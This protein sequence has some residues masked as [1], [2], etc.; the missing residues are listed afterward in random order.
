MS[1]TRHSNT[2]RWLL[3]HASPLVAGG[4]AQCVPA[5]KTTRLAAQGTPAADLF[6]LST[7]I[8]YAV[9][10][11]IP[12]TEGAEQQAQVMCA[13]LSPTFATLLLKGVHPRPQER[14]QSVSELL[15]AMGQHPTRRDQGMRRQRRRSTLGQFPQQATPSPMQ[16]QNHRAPVVPTPPVELPRRAHPPQGGRQR[17]SPEDLSPVAAGRDRLMA[18]G[19]IS[20]VLLVGVLILLLAR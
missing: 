14:Y 2:S 10:G 19:W 5:L 4:V 8:Y 13:G 15:E 3:T 17:V 18:W 6:M 9:I 1:P 11:R 7:V 16:A 20:G 12:P